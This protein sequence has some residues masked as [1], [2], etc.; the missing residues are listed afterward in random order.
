MAAV[1][2]GQASADTAYYLARV[3][4]DRGKSTDARKLLDSALKATGMFFCRKDAQALFDKLPPAAK[5]K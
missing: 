3:L 2:G 1:S 5:E 4:E